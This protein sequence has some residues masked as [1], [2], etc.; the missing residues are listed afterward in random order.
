MKPDR[1]KLAASVGISTRLL[2]RQL[3]GSSQVTDGH[4]RRIAEAAGLV[5]LPVSPTGFIVAIP[6]GEGLYTFQRA[7]VD[8]DLDGPA[9]PDLEELR[10]SFGPGYES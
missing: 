4:A 2:G 5:L 1:R 8:V 7:R 6:H 9:T 3:G 10:P